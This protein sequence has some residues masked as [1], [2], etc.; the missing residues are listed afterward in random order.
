MSDEQKKATATLL[1]FQDRSFSAIQTLLGTSSKIREYEK[2]LRKAGGYT[3]RVAE[4]QLTSFS[5]VMKKFKNNVGLAA[6]ELGRALAPS[7]LLITRGIQGVTDWFKRMNKTTQKWIAIAMTVLAVLGPMIWLIGLLV[8][9]IALATAGILGITAAG[10]VW[11]LA[12]VVVVVALWALVDAVTEADLG[13]LSLYNNMKTVNGEDF[14]S[15]WER[16]GMS[17]EGY[18]HNLG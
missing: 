17:I 4:V 9:T 10:V 11:A 12:I 2:A 15:V 1:G 7:L 8:K 16:A 13:I 5:S 6:E 18:L 14:S 3:K